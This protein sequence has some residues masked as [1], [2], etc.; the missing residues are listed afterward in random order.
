ME[1]FRG[2]K[3]EDLIASYEPMIGKL[4]FQYY[5][6]SSSPA[7]ELDDF[8]Q[9][10]RIGFI[11]AVRSFDEKKGTAFS[12]YVDNG[13]RIALRKLLS[14][15][16]RLIRFP[17]YRIEQLSRLDKAE[18]KVGK[19]A[20]ISSL[21]EEMG[22]KKEKVREL[23]ALRNTAIPLYLDNAEDEKSI[24]SCIGVEDFSSEA[25]DGIMLSSLEDE[26]GR[27][28]GPDGYILKSL[29]GSFGCSRKSRKEL[30]RELN[31]SYGTIER[32]YHRSLD[33]LRKAL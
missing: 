3:I 23:K 27:L 8:L 25:V 21:S 9:E 33:T 4:A 7:L 5:S 6:A 13:I 18:R 19:D 31:L 14:D 17:K 15:S 24:V 1:V 29:S 2:K 10:G 11:S 22:M 30:S 28:D 32:S 20:D 16:S 26:I 12:S